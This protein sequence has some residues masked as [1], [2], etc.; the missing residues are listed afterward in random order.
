MAYN[1]LIVDDSATPRSTVIRAI[2][3]SGL[4]VGRVREAQGGVEALEVL[5]K[6]RNDKADVAISLRTEDLHPMALAVFL[7]KRG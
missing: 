3:R 1:A 6:A 5:G 7:R 4:A 2:H